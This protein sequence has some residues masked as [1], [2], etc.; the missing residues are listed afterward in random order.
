MGKKKRF[1]LTLFLHITLF[2]LIIWSIPFAGT[3]FIEIPEGAISG[4]ETPWVGGGDDIEPEFEEENPMVFVGIPL[5]IRETETKIVEVKLKEF[6]PFQLLFRGRP[7]SSLKYSASLNSPAFDI[8]PS[9]SP[10]QK[11]GKGF[12]RWEW[13]ISPKKIGSHKLKIE[14]DKPVISLRSIKKINEAKEGHNFINISE[15]SLVS[16]I[17]VLNTLGLTA[18]QDA[19]FK[20]VGAVLAILGT[21]LGYP[22]W[23]RFISEGSFKKAGRKPGNKR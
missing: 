19:I 12:I 7:Y 4:Y 18:T 23:K 8:S 16:P 2:I 14:F 22:F 13:L 21:I 11:T 5:Y 9:V 1:A 15:T 17:T 3:L 10:I 6:L 20:A